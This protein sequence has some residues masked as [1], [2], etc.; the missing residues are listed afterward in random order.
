MKK[1]NREIAEERLKQSIFYYF[2]LHEKRD[3]YSNS[4]AF[5]D[6]LLAVL[7]RIFF[8]LKRRKIYR[9]G[10]E[11]INDI[12]TIS[13]LSPLCGTELDPKLN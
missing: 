5:F 2:L 10:E 13:K 9:A 6:L 12:L 4:F 7:Q 3:F 8:C 11:N 1:K